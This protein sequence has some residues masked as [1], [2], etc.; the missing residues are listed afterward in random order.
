MVALTLLALLALGPMNAH[1]GLRLV[2]EVSKAKVYRG[3][4]FNCQFVL[5]A[6]ASSLETEVSKFPEFRGY[7]SENTTLRQ[8]P[9]FLLPDPFNPTVRKTVIGSYNLTAMLGNSGVQISPMKLVV[10]ILTAA[11]DVETSLTSESSPLTVLPLPPVPSSLAESFQGA[12][13]NLLL[14][15]QTERDRFY[16]QEPV[17]VRHF[18]TGTGNFPDVGSLRL[19]LPPEARLVNQKSVVRNMPGTTAKVFETTLLIEATK[20]ITIP[21]AEF[22]RFNTDR[23]QYETT[24]TEPILLEYS[25]RPPAPADLSALDLGP[26]LPFK[27][28]PSP[29]IFRS[30]NFLLAAIWLTLL[31][32]KGARSRQ[33]KRQSDPRIQLKRRWD[34]TLKSPSSDLAWWVQ[35]ENLIFQTLKF[36]FPEAVTRES[37]LRKAAALW[38]P[39]TAGYLSEVCRFVSHAEFSGSPA[40]PVPDREPLQQTTRRLLSKR[41]K[42]EP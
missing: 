25:E 41:P 36:R 15:A 9:T 22:T 32:V 28:E 12:V 21:G 39:R 8:G 29:W 23:G 6:D 31:G 19:K 16:P 1:A 26:L 18:L 37:A 33:R 10:K 38:G 4:T 7:W 20:N 35:V 2:A 27:G 24:Q 5:Y 14:T 3:E 13:G 34:E 42:K 17:V 30:L 11:G 40:G